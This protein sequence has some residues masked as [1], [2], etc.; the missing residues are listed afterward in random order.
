MAYKGLCN[1]L[2]SYLD[3]NK[4]YRKVFHNV[5]LVWVVWPPC[6]RVKWCAIR[7]LALNHGYF[8]LVAHLA[9]K[10]FHHFDHCGTPEGRRSHR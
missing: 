6:I 9:V 4:K 2:I 3:A 10:R 7:E 1:I 5:F 8:P